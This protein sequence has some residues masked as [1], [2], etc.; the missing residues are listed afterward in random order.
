VGGAPYLLVYHL[1]TSAGVRRADGFVVDAAPADARAYAQ[2]YA[3]GAL[4]P[5]ARHAGG[6]GAVT[7]AL[8]RGD[9]VAVWSSNAAHGTCST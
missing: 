8:L 7:A 3:A 6:A 4:L 2:A 9:G 1:D 5:D